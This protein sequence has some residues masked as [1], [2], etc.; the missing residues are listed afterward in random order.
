[1]SH[2]VTATPMPSNRMPAIT[3]NRRSMT[4][5]T[6]LPAED[7]I[8]VRKL[9]KAESTRVT[10]VILIAQRFLF[11]LCFLTGFLPD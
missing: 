6:M 5:T 11:F 2:E 3:M 7:V 8:S 4:V 10:T 9:M 1:M